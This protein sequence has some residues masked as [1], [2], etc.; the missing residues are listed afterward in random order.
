MSPPSP[1]TE[2]QRRVTDWAAEL[3]AASAPHARHY[4]H[5]L[6]ARYQRQE[7]SSEQVLTL[8]D[9]SPY[10][11]LY[12]SR[13]TR[14]FA[15]AEL[16]EM[17]TAARL[18]NTRHRLTGLLLHSNGC[19]VQV[20]EGPKAE[21]QALYARIQQDARHTHIVTVSEG[22]GAARRFGNWDMALGRV[23]GSAVVRAFE[24]L[25]LRQEASDGAS[26]DRL[27]SA[28][29]QAFHVHLPSPASLAPLRR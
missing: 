27:L 5:Q 19:F 20:L 6:L 3:A 25:L 11:V 7:L 24:T 23:A 1:N 9:A 13:A 21:V 16:Q 26:S 18:Y 10:H 2:A 28:L 14:D 12:R 29:I 17:L 15:E 8:L 22:L 4:E